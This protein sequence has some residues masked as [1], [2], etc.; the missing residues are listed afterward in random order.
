MPRPILGT[1]HCKHSG[2]TCQPK[3]QSWSV[4]LSQY[5]R[6]LMI[7][8]PIRHKFKLTEFYLYYLTCLKCSNASTQR[9]S[10]TLEPSASPHLLEH[11]CLSSMSLFL[12]SHVRQLALSI[13]YLTSTTNERMWPA[14]VHVW[15]FGAGVGE[16]KYW[17][18]LSASVFLN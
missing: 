17:E 1:G 13:S 18:E 10:V 8:T 7:L 16:E 12:E 5:N 14:C 4:L 2:H 15:V 3:P 11:T 6:D 9:L